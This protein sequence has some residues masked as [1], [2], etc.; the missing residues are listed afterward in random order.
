M[1]RYWGAIDGPDI[2]GLAMTPLM[3]CQSVAPASPSRRG[4]Y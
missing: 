4:W 1:G 2:D 3:E